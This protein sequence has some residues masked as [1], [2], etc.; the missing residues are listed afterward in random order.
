MTEQKR[1]GALSMPSISIA[2]TAELMMDDPRRVALE[3]RLAHLKGAKSLSMALCTSL[4]IEAKRHAGS[5]A[6]LRPSELCKKLGWD[7]S[8]MPAKDLHSIL[9]ECGFI[10][11][12]G[13]A[14][15]DDWK[16]LMEKAIDDESFGGYIRRKRLEKYADDGVSTISYSAD[17][18]GISRTY[19]SDIELDR[20]N[21]APD[22]LAKIAQYLDIPVGE[23]LDKSLSG[24]EVY[25][26]RRHKNGGKGVPRAT[27]G[28]VGARLQKS[29]NML[30][31]PTLL[32]IDA[33][34]DKLSIANDVDP[35]MDRVTA[36]LVSTKPLPKQPAPPPNE[37][38]LAEAGKA[39]KPTKK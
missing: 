2:S 5:F 37:P 8:V 18:C 25:T 31:V 16:A 36:A 23:M 6:D 9:V 29:W 7:T 26:L 32:A 33:A 3:E 1:V 20:R 14:V 13:F 19:W 30:D 21:P 35:M 17:E 38:T 10:T 4:R 28:H 15:F 34:L 12:E 24:Q 22:V 39:K 27:L 11:V